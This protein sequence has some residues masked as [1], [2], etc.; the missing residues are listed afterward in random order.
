M[1]QT[2]AGC[3]LLGLVG[4][5]AV[6]QA[7]QRSQLYLLLEAWSRCRVAVMKLCS[8]LAGQDQPG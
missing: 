2:L 5:Q 7:C 6:L 3:C 8:C 1:E 4:T